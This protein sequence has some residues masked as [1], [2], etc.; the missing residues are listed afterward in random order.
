MEGMVQ[1]RAPTRAVPANIPALSKE[2][3][4]LKEKQTLRLITARASDKRKLPVARWGGA[5]VETH[6]Q[7]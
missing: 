6:L 7:G 4:H 5:M 1:E 2:R 3:D